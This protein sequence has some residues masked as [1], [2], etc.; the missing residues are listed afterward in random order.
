MTKEEIREIIGKDWAAFNDAIFPEILPSWILDNF[1]KIIWESRQKDY[2]MFAR[3]MVSILSKTSDLPKITFHEAGLILN[4]KN[5]C[6]PF[7]VADD[8]D[9]YIERKEI[10]TKIQF[11]WNQ[12]LEKM[13]QRMSRKEDS[14]FK[15][16]QSTPKI[17]T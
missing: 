17:I 2:P 14:L 1:Q 5:Q 13:K 10:M 16:L 6:E 4:I 15:G 11:R 7:H 3:D 8:W 9:T 12:A